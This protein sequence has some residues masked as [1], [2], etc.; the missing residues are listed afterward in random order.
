[1]KTYLAAPATMEPAIIEVCH[2]RTGTIRHLPAARESKIK[3]VPI[4]A[5]FRTC[6]VL[7]RR[8]PGSSR[9]KR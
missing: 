5:G 2:A 6:F 4:R 7:F 1:M 3:R 9:N 8:F